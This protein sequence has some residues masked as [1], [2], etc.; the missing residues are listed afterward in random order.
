VF[1]ITKNVACGIMQA[2]HKGEEY[3]KVSANYLVNGV[4]GELFANLEKF[5]GDTNLEDLIRCLEFCSISNDGMVL[6]NSR[7]TEVMLIVNKCFQTNRTLA[8]E[9]VLIVPDINILYPAATILL[10]LTANEEI[11][12]KVSQEMM[13]HN[14]FEFIIKYPLPALMNKDLRQ[15]QLRKMRDLFIGIVLN[16]TCNIEDAQMTSYFINEIDILKT[17]M[18]IL[19]DKRQDWPTQGA[20]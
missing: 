17:L 18:Q 12:G 16:I 3:E 19:E 14:M 13:N 15:T 7:I 4:F 9:S 11:I 20:A 5:I 6:I 8:D 2:Y 1:Q 10:D